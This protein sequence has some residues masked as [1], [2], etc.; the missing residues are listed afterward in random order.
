[1]LFGRRKRVVERLLIVEDEPLVAFDNERFLEDEGYTI[2]GTFDSVADATAVITSGVPIDLILSD[3]S[4]ADGSGLDVA[5]A[6][7]EAGL[8]V[9]FVTGDCPPEGA[10]LAHGWLAKPYDPRH[11]VQAISIIDQRLQGEA[12]KRLPEGLT[13][14]DRAA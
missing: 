1:M 14:F 13:L 12:L 4:L 10:T 2:V 6:A 9:L 8:N 5:R 3:I 11:L 7:L